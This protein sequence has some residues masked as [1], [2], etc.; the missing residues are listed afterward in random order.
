MMMIMLIP[1]MAIAKRVMRNCM[2]KNKQKH[3]HNFSSTADRTR[4]EKCTKV[5]GSN[6]ATQSV[7][8]MGTTT[9]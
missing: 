9:A 4:I 3:Q 2:E 6:P 8:T 1:L 5:V 7:F